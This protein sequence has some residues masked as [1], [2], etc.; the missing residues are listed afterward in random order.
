MQHA[1]A[2]VQYWL[3]SEGHRA[4]ILNPLAT[5]VGVGFAENYSAPSI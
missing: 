1:I 3:T 5:E 2:P 4:I